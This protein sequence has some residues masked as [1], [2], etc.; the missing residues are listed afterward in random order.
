MGIIYCAPN[1][2]TSSASVQHLYR[3]WSVRSI[4]YT[5]LALTPL[6]PINNGVWD[7]YTMC[8]GTHF[9]NTCTNTEQKNRHGIFIQCTACD[10]LQKCLHCR[11]RGPGHRRYIYIYILHPVG[12]ECTLYE[13]H[14]LD[15]A[16]QCKYYIYIWGKDNTLLLVVVF[17]TQLTG[18]IVNHNYHS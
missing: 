15:S 14:S 8:L 12:R 1:R 2:H 7:L 5:L 13:M 10:S 16:H 18:R 11:Y 3:K 4:F 6:V 17:H 9:I